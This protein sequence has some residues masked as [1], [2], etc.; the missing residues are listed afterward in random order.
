MHAHSS[1]NLFTLMGLLMFLVVAGGIHLRDN[2]SY[3]LSFQ[4]VKVKSLEV[5][6]DPRRELGLTKNNKEEL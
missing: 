1:D 5:K 6:E 2:L 3:R 4:D